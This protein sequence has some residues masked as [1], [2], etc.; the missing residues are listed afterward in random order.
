MPRLDE[1]PEPLAADKPAPKDDP[2]TDDPK[3][4]TTDAWKDILFPKSGSGA[5]AGEAWKH[6]AASALHGWELHKLHTGKP[7]KLDEATYKAAIEASTK[8]VPAS[9]TDTGKA[10]DNAYT[11]VPHQAALSP[12]MQ[13]GGEK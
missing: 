12:A 5:P 3:L 7:L 10:I 8:M 9:H 11:Y 1:Q 6:G 4:K 13:K 2:E